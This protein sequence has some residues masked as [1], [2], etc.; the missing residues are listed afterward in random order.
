M[1]FWCVTAGVILVSTGIFGQAPAKNVLK[2]E[3]EWVG[4]YVNQGPSDLGRFSVETILGDPNNQ[5]D[6]HQPLIFGRPIPWSSYTTILIDGQPFVF[7]GVNKKIEKRAGKEAFFG[8]FISQA[9]TNEGVVTEYRYNR[10]RVVQT[11]SFFRNPSTRVKD[12]VQ[13]KYDILN[14]DT[15]P[16]NVGLRIMLDTKLGQNDGA[17]FRIGEKSITSEMMFSGRDIQEFWQS[18]DSLESP[19]V[20]AQGLLSLPDDGITS[21]DRLYLANW[22]KLADNPWDAPLE[23]GHSF[24]REGETDQDTSLAMYWDDKPVQPNQQRTVKTVYGIGGVSVAYGQ[25]TLGLTAPAELYA[26]HG[27]EISLLGYVTNSGGYDAKDVDVDF[28]LPEGFEPVSGKTHYH[29]PQMRRGETGQYALKVRI[30]A[31]VSGVV[32]IRLKV[33]STTLDPNT[34][35]RKIELLSPPAIRAKFEVPTSKVSSLNRLIDIPVTLTNTGSKSIDKVSVILDPSTNWDLPNFEVREK[36]IPKLGPSQHTQL[37]WRIQL[38]SDASILV[39]L[40]LR[41]K[42]DVTSEKVVTA[43]ITLTSPLMESFLSLSVPTAPIGEF[44]YAKLSLT[45]APV[46]SKWSATILYDPTQLKLG[47]YS[48]ELWVSEAPGAFSTGIGAIYLRQIASVTELTDATVAKFHFKL[49]TEGDIP[50]TLISDGKSKTIILKG[51]KK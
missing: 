38:K 14:S 31:D 29:I 18:F 23:M 30:T 15:V 39:R 28:E 2:L 6:D 8:E 46:L 40:Q 37:N 19:T 48:P 11:L 7:G 26:F 34:L 50:I 3:N 5:R 22:G 17:P 20:I 35:E 13:I 43:D 36:I 9:V 33:K 27:R 21:P 47:W 25:F 51:T 44:V 16:H 4:V 41:H 10:I 24:V 12:S 49:L 1:R 32:P 45:N 42:S